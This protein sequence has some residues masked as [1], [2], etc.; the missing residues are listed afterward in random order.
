MA[1]VYELKDFRY[2][3][4]N[5]VLSDSFLQAKVVPLVADAAARRAR[6]RTFS[7]R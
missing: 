3:K 5:L 2:R 1:L 4:S 6:R 7:C